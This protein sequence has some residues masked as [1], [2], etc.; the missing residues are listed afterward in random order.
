[1]VLIVCHRVTKMV[2]QPPARVP[3]NALAV[4]LRNDGQSLTRPSLAAPLCPTRGP[5]TCQTSALAIGRHEA[6]GESPSAS[7]GVVWST[8]RAGPRTELHG[9]RTD[10]NSSA[11]PDRSSG[12]QRRSADLPTPAR[13]QG[14]RGPHPRP[15]RAPTRRGATLSCPTQGASDWLKSHGPAYPP[16][17][18]TAASRLTVAG[19]GPSWVENRLCGCTQLAWRPPE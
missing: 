1:M 17:R 10:A 13:Q 3:S 12:A 16:A 4:S 8:G 15:G 11:G 9:A 5:P 19:G 2:M 18:V 14:S 6:R 7:N